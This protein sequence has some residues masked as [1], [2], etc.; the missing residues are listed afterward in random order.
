MNTALETRIRAAGAEMSKPGRWRIALSQ[1]DQ[2]TN[3]ILNAPEFDMHAA[4]TDLENLQ[5]LYQWAP[6]M[7]NHEYHR[8]NQ[9]L[10]QLTEAITKNS[11][12]A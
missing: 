8:L 1:L 3:Q 5:M 11:A 9:L 7:Q 10:M 6:V 2:T 12:S 4:Q